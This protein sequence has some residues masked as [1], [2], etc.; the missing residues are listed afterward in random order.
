MRYT[1]N[2]VKFTDFKSFNKNKL[3]KN[4]KTFYEGK[5]LLIVPHE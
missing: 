2:A 4:V 5:S 3:K 1:Y